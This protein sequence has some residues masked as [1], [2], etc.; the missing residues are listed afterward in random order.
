MTNKADHITSEI[1]IL[2]EKIENAKKILS[3]IKS[4][5][6]TDD[7]VQAVVEAKLRDWTNKRD[8]YLN[9]LLKQIKK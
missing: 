7:K 9:L 4:T 3:T 5:K 1:K 2:D 8:V 6:N